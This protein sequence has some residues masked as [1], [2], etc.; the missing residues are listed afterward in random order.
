MKKVI[1][2]NPPVPKSKESET[3]E[4]SKSDQKYLIFKEI[5]NTNPEHY[6][7]STKIKKTLL[8]YQKYQIYKN[9]LEKYRENHKIFLYEET[10]KTLSNSHCEHSKKKIS[11]TKTK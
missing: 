2:L 4:N 11:L 5:I 6:K 3:I 9:M 8:F 10:I 1:I 7:N